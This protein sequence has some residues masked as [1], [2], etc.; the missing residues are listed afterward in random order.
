MSYEELYLE[1][2][3]QMHDVTEAKKVAEVLGE[4]LGQYDEAWIGREKYERD[5]KEQLAGVLMESCA[6]IYP[7]SINEQVCRIFGALLKKLYRDGYINSNW[8]GVD[9]T[10]RFEKALAETQ[11]PGKR[12]ALNDLLAIIKGMQETCGRKIDYAAFK[13]GMKKEHRRIVAEMDKNAFASRKLLDE[14]RFD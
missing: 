6:L 11:A 12:Y 10:S 5:E 3:Y 9:L 7:S 8:K 2:L 14:L 1:L 4:L 13:A